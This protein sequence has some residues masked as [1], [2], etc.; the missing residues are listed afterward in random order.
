MSVAATIG[1]PALEIVRRQEF[2]IVEEY[3]YLN[4]ASQGPWPKRTTAA[5]QR[6]AAL[7]QY[8]NTDRIL[9]EPAAEPQARARLAR[10][11]NA[12]P[13]D[14]VFTGNTTH[15]MNICAQGIDWRP[16][17][18]VVLPAREFP[19]LGYAWLN[20]KQRG[21]EVRRVPVTGAGPALDDLI[22]ATDARTRAI[23]CSAISWDTGYRLDLERLGRHCAERGC[24]L[25]VDGIQAIG[26]VPV[27]VQAMRISAIATHAYKWLMAGFGIG[28]LYVAPAAIDQIRPT[29]IG[30]QS[31]ATVDDEV[32][33]EFDWQPGAARY[34][35][36]GLN[37]TGLA[38]LNASLGLIE[39][40]GIE[41]IAEHDRQLAERLYGGL[42]RQADRLQIVTSNDPVHRAAIV[43]FTLGDQQR[44]AALVD[45]LARRQV[46]VALRPLGVRASPHFYNNEAEVDRLLAEV[47]RLLTTA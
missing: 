1:R 8:P 19:S 26:A 35:A 4:A 42:S 21:V 40:I 46:I 44:D 32:V 15:G 41:A 45:E 16:G 2:P 9:N 12:D 7:S 6:W 3:T 28:A 10:L 22:A 36:G 11:I 17:D 31:V 25:I 39:E 38:G 30:S 5:V 27:D 13:A 23:S 29:F 20:L 33:E 43:T 14:L 24:L 47:S 34:S 18:N 37:R